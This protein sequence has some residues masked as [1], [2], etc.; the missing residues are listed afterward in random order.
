MISERMI[1]FLKTYGNA[2]EQEEQRNGESSRKGN[3][4]EDCYLVV[5]SIHDKA[6]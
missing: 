3:A 1:A 6:C 4:L 5:R 2:S